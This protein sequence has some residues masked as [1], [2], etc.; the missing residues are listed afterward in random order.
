MATRNVVA[1]KLATT[2][3]DQSSCTLWKVTS[4]R[5]RP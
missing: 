1:E 2:G 5:A 3:S 4:V